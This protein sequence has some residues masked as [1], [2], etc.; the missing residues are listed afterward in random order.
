MCQNKGEVQLPIQIE[1]EVVYGW[2][3]IEAE[4]Q[5][6]EGVFSCLI[7]DGSSLAVRL[8]G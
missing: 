1:V 6:K 8:S 5:L 7:I 4:A 2:G 3:C